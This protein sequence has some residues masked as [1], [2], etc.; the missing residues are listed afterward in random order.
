MS[1]HKWTVYCE[2]MSKW[3]II[4]SVAKPTV[5][6]SMASHTINLDSITEEEPEERVISSGHTYT[7]NTTYT[8]MS[9][10]IF[11]GTDHNDNV[12]FIQGTVT[13]VDG[14]GDV[15]IYDVTNDKVIASSGVLTIASTGI[16]DFS[17]PAN[18]SAN[19]AIWEIQARKISGTE[20]IIFDSIILLL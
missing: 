5:C 16:V 18:L 10:F 12:T 15:R 1:K 4:W 20:D 11:R 17:I 6:P 13:V 8:R 2:T 3:E 9:Q 7:Q 19:D 14:T